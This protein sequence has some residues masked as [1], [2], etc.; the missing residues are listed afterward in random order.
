MMNLRYLTLPKTAGID[1][2]E[3]SGARVLADKDVTQ[4]E[5][6]TGFVL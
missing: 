1:V 2:Q 3:V 6:L 5:C 4:R